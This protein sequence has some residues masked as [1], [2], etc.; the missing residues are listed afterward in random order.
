MKGGKKNMNMN[1]FGPLELPSNSK[2]SMK[3]QSY[4]QNIKKSI[5]KLFLYPKIEVCDDF[6]HQNM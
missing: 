1:M 2:D 6:R 5:Y 4:L 3:I